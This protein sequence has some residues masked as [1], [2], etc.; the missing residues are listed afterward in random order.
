[1][2]IYMLFLLSISTFLFSDSTNI[3]IGKKPFSI[4]ISNYNEYGTKGQV[5]SIYRGEM[6]NERIFTF[7]LNEVKGACN[8]KS[9]QEGM[10]EIN[11]STITFYT[12]WTREANAYASPIG[13]RIERYNI[14]HNSTLQKTSSKLYIEETTKDYDKESAIKYLFNPPKNQKERAMLKEYTQ[15]LEDRY[16]STFIFDKE[17]HKLMS[18]VRK[19]FSRNKKGFWD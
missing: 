15:Y 4:S 5:L 12:R 10:Y 3:V 19:A 6:K 2:K 11:A 18:E 17:S 14:L 13:A 16:K 7:I 9:I 8:A 1:M